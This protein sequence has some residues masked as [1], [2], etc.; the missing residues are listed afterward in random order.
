MERALRL[1]H[2][3]RIPGCRDR[4]RVFELEQSLQRALLPHGTLPEGKSWQLGRVQCTRT[5][6]LVMFK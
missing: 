5:K 2:V 1:E 4:K 3:Q 6:G